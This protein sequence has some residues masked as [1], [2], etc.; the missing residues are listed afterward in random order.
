[1]RAAVGAA[2]GACRGSV[3]AAGRGLRLSLLREEGERLGERPGGERRA[4]PRSP[5]VCQNALSDA[6]EPE[7][8][9]FCLSAHLR[10]VQS[11]C[12][13]R[14]YCDYC[15]T[16]LTHDSVSPSF[17]PQRRMQSQVLLRT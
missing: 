10:T 11:F 3:R 6:L 7:L 5:G 15:D 9:A 14:F 1:M 2:A 17:S 12:L 4:S 13:A 16:Y 8:E